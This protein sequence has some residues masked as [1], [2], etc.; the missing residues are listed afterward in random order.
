V[1]TVLVSCVGGKKQKLAIHLFAIDRWV[2]IG[3]DWKARHDWKSQFV[4]LIGRIG[5]DC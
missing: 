5:L 2:M 1:F 4:M 3:K